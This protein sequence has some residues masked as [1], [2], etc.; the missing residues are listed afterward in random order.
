MSE[1]DAFCVCAAAG[2]DPGERFTFRRQTYLVNYDRD[3]AV[4]A[5]PNN[6]IRYPCLFVYR[7]NDDKA[8]RAVSRMFYNYIYKRV[9]SFSAFAEIEKTS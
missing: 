2:R 5:F 3:F 9:A 7:R 6:L 4:V 8:L 1:L